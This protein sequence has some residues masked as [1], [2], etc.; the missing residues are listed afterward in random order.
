MTAK[1]TIARPGMA[2]TSSQR[3]GFAAAAASFLAV[4]AAGALPIPLYDTYRLSDGV[5]NTGL[6]LVAVTYFICAVLALLFLGRLSDHLGRKPVTSAALGVAMVGCIVLANVHGLASLLIGRGLQGAAAGVAASAIAAYAADTAP[7]RP[8]WLL[9]TVTSSSTNVGLAVGA[10]G[11]G[12]LVDFAPLPTVLAYLLGVIVLAGCAVLV[13][14]GSEPVTRKPGVWRSL[15]PRIALPAAV[16]PYLPAMAAVFVSTWALGGYYQAFGPSVAV[17]DLHSSSALVAAA[18]FASYMAP[19]AFGGPLISRWTPAAGQRSGMLLVVV[20]AAGLT[21]AIAVS[22]AVVFVVAGVV[23]GVGMGAAMSSSMRAVMPEAAPHER[24]GLL[25]LV[26]AISYSG[27][28]VPSLIAGQLARTLTLVD[29]TI[30]YGL[31][32]VLAF[33][34]V[35]FTARNPIV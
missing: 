3:T 8:R 24:A 20:A 27:A 19:S 15:R 17:D 35:T 9:P 28:A 21:M 30:G 2:R 12:A 23:G 29:I 31:L 10:F 1:G 7:D 22:N 26:Y 32:A 18:V 5:T 11:A 6:S 14:F 4:F 34:I 13:F 25:A 16:R 33:V